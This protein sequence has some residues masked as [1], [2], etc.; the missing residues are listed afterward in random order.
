MK[1]GV[2]KGIR[3]DMSS[4]TDTFMTVAVLAAVAK[5]TK[6]SIYNIANQRLKES[7]RILAMVT[8]LAKCGVTGMSV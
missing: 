6:T 7:N 1:T 5:G 3:I 2:L 4:M 8:E